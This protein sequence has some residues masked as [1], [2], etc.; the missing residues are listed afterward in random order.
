MGFK[1]TPVGTPTV[2]NNV[3]VYGK[4]AKTT[5]KPTPAEPQDTAPEGAPTDPAEPVVE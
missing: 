4:V 3:S 5:P 1:F 2:Q